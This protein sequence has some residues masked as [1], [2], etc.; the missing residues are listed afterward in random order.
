MS[1]LP[2]EC[3]WEGQKFKQQEEQLKLEFG[4]DSGANTHFLEEGIFNHS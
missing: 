2:Y 4:Q 3:T 1:K